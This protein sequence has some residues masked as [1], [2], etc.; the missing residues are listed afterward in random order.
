MA[1]QEIKRIS[2]LPLS[3]DVTDNDLLILV[4]I[5][6]QSLSPSGRTKRVKVSSFSDYLNISETDPV[7]T[8]SVASSITV[9]NIQ[10]WNAA[11]EWGDHSS[12]GYLTS[13]TESDPTFT[14]SPAYNVTNLSISNWNTA[15][16]WGNHASAGYL[17]S[18]S[19]YDPV[20]QSSAAFA[21][22][23]TK[24]NNWDSAYGWGNHANAGY[25]K[26]ISG[27]S[28]G[29]LSDTFISSPTNGQFLKFNGT[30]WV[31]FTP[32]F[33]DDFEETDTLQSVTE[34]GASTDVECTFENV[35]ISGNL[36]V[37]GTTTQNNVTTLNVSDNEIIIND[38][39]ASGDL[40]AFITNDRGT[41]ANVSIKWNE[42]SNRWQ[43][44]NDGT[45]YYN[46]A[47][48]TS[49]LT[50]NSGFLTTLGSVG[51]HS[52]VILTSPASEDILI[53]NG[54]EWVNSPLDFNPRVFVSTTEPTSPVEGNLWW[55]SNDEVLKVYYN[56]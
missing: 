37:V 40:N 49:D 22:T 13:F 20:F 25:L 6:D 33:L 50:N 14:S 28:F 43:F 39:Q 11:Y 29:D 42:A 1:S 17:K 56:M 46:L 34:R 10:N 19:E 23:T 15:Y 21:I 32:N 27:S 36:S 12:A 38:G 51:G 4:D 31:N 47:I 30:N 16:G 5:E 7:F 54:S 45:N 18:Y 44:T 8:S 35:I 48:N 3:S 52:D 24:I 9:G 2:D 55:K 41:D 26:N 53:Y